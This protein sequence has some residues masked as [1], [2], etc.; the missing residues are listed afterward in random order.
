MRTMV[1]QRVEFF[2]LPDDVYYMYNV[3][4]VYLKLFF[5]SLV[6]FIN[7]FLVAYRGNV[8]SIFSKHAY[9]SFPVGDSK[10]GNKHT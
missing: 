8:L 7:G 1:P 10:N 9:K 5:F 2:F 3:P 6:A 4:D